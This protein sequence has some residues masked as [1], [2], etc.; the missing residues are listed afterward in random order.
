MKRSNAIYWTASALVTIVLGASGALSALHAAPMMTAL[1]HLGYPRYFINILAVGKIVGLVIFLAP[2]MPRLKEWVYSGFTITILSA[3][4]S[5][6][7][8][9]DGWLAAEP[10]VTF[11]ALMTSYAFRPAGRRLP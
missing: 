7:S 8:S 5:H 10:L 2:K 6:L 1:H 3:C 11:A 9:G 4:Y